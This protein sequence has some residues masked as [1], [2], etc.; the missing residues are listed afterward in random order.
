MKLSADTLEIISSIATIN[1]GSPVQGAVFKKGNEI[2]ARRYKSAAPIM[3]ATIAEEFPREFAVYDLKKFLNIFKIIEDPEI[4]FNDEYISFKSGKKSAKIK[5]VSPNLI[6]DPSFFEKTIKMPEVDFKCEVSTDTLKT[7]KT[8]SSLM[9]T[10]EIA[11][12]SDG[13]TV[14]L[15]TYNTRD[16]KS[17]KFEIEVG[18]CPRKFTI[19]V[20]LSL[21]QFINSDYNVSISLK[22]LLE[23]K[24]DKITY[25]ITCSEKS[26]VK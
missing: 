5:Y 20:D 6:E 13:E 8:A 24:S 16:T 4:T 9:A 22:G 23:W 11:F 10:P 21:I 25:Y 18:E 1:A 12:I 19:I 2:K 26:K 3:Y 15:T 7:I 17:D 14:K